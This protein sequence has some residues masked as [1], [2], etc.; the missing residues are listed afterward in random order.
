VANFPIAF[1]QEKP[2]GVA[3][4]LKMITI[5]VLLAFLTISTA[6]H[7]DWPSFLGGVERDNQSIE[8]PT[9]WSSSQGLVWK[10]ALQGHGQSSPVVVGDTVYLTAIDGPQKERNLVLAFDLRTGEK[11]WE[12]I[13][14]NSLQAKNDAYTSR[15]APTAAADAAGVVAFFESGDIV[16]LTPTGEVRWER[17]LIN[18]YGKYE[19]RFG[20]GASLA[21]LQD[22]VFALA[23]NEGPSYLIALSKDTGETLWKTD[24]GSRTSWSSPMML[25]VNGKPQIVVSSAGSIDGYEPQEGKLLWTMGDLG[26]NTVASPIPFGDGCFLVGASPGRN[27]EKSEDAMRSNMAVRITENDNQYQSTVL[28]R[29][30][31]ASSSFGSPMVYQD[32]AYYVNRSGGMFCIDALSGKLIYKARIKEPIWATPFGASDRVYF[33]GQKGT[34]T[35][36]KAGDEHEELAANRLWE[37]SADG[38]GPGGFDAE[39]QYGVAI[40]SRGLLIRTGQNLYLVQGAVQ[41]SP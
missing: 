11:S 18:D 13:F 6:T 12:H 35:V 37:P 21:Q 16:A 41:Q 33:F 2:S 23:D 3:M 29:N 24:R 10:T 26:G 38:G 39:I 40:T 27:G 22:R 1:F 25:T 15:A 14:A 7:A 31:E 20:L 8:L 30:E 32:N 9:N 4:Q 5:G 34:T 36:V 19:G 17:K 28:W